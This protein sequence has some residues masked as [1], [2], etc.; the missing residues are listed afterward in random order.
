VREIAAFSSC[1]GRGIGR[2][3]VKAIVIHA[4]KHGSHTIRLSCPVELPA[5]EFYSSPGFRRFHRPSKPGKSRP[6]YQ[7]ELVVREA[8]P[9]T[10]VA[11]LTN[12]GNDLRNLLPLWEK[13]GPTQ[14]PFDHCIITPLFVDPRTFSCVRHMRDSW[15]VSVWFDSGGFYVQQDKIR[16]EQLF[17]RLLDFY[18]HHDWAEAYV[19]PDY[20]PTSRSSIEEV[21]ERVRVTAA[22]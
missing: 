3:L 17:V 1:Q 6:L 16:Y 8:R 5:N 7:W 12:A 22:E 20:V 21:E 10:F 2:A 4:R 19:L 11:S 14:R 18:R 9:L 15:G 13:E